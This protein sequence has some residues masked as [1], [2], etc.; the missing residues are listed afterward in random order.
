VLGEHDSTAVQVPI[1]RH[2]TLGAGLGVP[3]C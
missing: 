3:V 1:D 2:L